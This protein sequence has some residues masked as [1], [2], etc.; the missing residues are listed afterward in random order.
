MVLYWKSTGM[1]GRK[2]GSPFRTIQGLELPSHSGGGERWLS[3]E[4]ILEIQPIRCERKD[5]RMTGRFLA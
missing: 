2:A 1:R 3:T 5:W 4:Y